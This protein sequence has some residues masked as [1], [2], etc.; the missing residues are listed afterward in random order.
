MKSECA[1]IVGTDVLLGVFIF[2][3]NWLQLKVMA[4][5]LFLARSL[6][7]LFSYLSLYLVSI[8]LGCG[9]LIPRFF[10]SADIGQP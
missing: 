2:L 7:F 5:A 1:Q 8:R 9:V 3:Y 4:L 10:E 6:F